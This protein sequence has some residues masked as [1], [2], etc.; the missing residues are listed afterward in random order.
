VTGPLDAALLPNERVLMIGLAT[1]SPAAARPMEQIPVPTKAGIESAAS[2][3][4]SRSV[5]ETY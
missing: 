4:T 3:T 1:F 5:G 2:P